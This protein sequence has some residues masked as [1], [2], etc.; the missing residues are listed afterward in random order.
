[1]SVYF[2]RTLLYSNPSCTTKDVTLLSSSTAS[3]DSRF[4]NILSRDASSRWSLPTC[5]EL[6]C[7]CGAF[8][9]SKGR[10]G[11]CSFALCALVW[12][13]ATVSVHS[14]EEPGT[15]PKITSQTG[16]F[17]THASTSPEKYCDFNTIRAPGNWIRSPLNCLQCF[18][19]PVDWSGL[20]NHFRTPSVV[21]P[22]SSITSTSLPF[23]DQHKSSANLSK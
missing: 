11:L 8:V 7:S 3:T 22:E 14:N 1:M 13:A 5:S 12:T 9:V 18:T 17:I 21:H 6:T 16:L 19:S 20:T 15:R 4:L 2:E 10:N 23:T